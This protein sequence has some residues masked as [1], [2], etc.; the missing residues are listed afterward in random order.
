MFFSPLPTPS[1]WTMTPAD[2]ALP[3]ESGFRHAGRTLRAVT[4]APTSGESLRCP[5]ACGLKRHLADGRTLLELEP[6]LARQPTLS[7][8]LSVGAP[9]FYLAT[10]R[11]APASDDIWLDRFEPLSSG[12]T[13]FAI[14]FADGIAREPDQAAALL[15]PTID[16]ALGDDGWS[17]FAAALAAAFGSLLLLDEAGA[18]VPTALLTLTSASGE[19]RRLE[20]LPEH[21]G[22]LFLAGVASGDLPATLALAGAA[23]GQMQWVSAGDTVVAAPDSAALVPGLRAVMHADLH[24]WFAPQFPSGSGRPLPRYTRGNRVLPLVNGPAYFADLF[25]ELN[26]ISGAETPGFHLTGYRIDPTAV[27]IARADGTAASCLE[28]AERIAAAG[29]RSCFLPM[30]FMQLEPE[31]EDYALAITLFVILVHATGLV[32]DAHDSPDG[33]S[34]IND[35]G[36]VWATGLAAFAIVLLFLAA[37]ARGIELNADAVSLLNRPGSVSRLSAPPATFRD[38]PLAT[39]DDFPVSALVNLLHRYNVFHQKIALVRND[40][41]FVGYCGG[42]DLNPDRLDDERHLAAAPYHDVQA[43]VEGPALR[44]LA[45]TFEERWTRD[46]VGPPAFAAD[47]VPIVQFEAPGAAIVQV[48]RT[49]H[50][51]APDAPA[52][53]RLPFAPAGDRTLL[54]TTLQALSRA[55]EHVY[56]EDQYLT[57][58]P[59][60]ARALIRLVRER[61]IRSLVAV[62]PSTPD[63]LF[64]AGLRGEFVRA[65]R[66]AD[67]GAG[68]VQV[69]YARRSYQLAGTSTAAAK[70]RLILGNDV[71]ASTGS[72]VELRLGPASRLPPLPFWVCI[73]GELL[74]AVRQISA[75]EE[76]VTRPDESGTAGASVD[77]GVRNARIIAL[78]G[79]AT[80][81]LDARRGSTPRPHRTGAAATV[82]KL[83]GIYMHAKLML[84]DD[85]FAGI[86]SANVNRRGYFSD[87]ECNVFVVPEAL[88]FAA[89]NP[90]RR[91]RRTLWA[92]LLDLPIAFVPLLD[93]AIAASRLFRRSYLMGNR[94]APYEAIPAAPF[95]LS[96]GFTLR[97][98]VSGALRVGLEAVMATIATTAA[99]TQRGVFYTLSDP[100]SF[101][102]TDLG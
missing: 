28:A 60:Y 57:P 22:D 48:A 3:W 42:V 101:L 75:D 74:L 93:D 8:R 61:Q 100:S 86:G 72:E 26:A 7:A 80:N 68:I 49:Y 90:V 87:G 11:P 27:L 41:G 53:R 55:R 19:V 38:N 21:R 5:A 76:A 47:D 66:D 12:G 94:F 62:V 63:Q 45:V 20:L 44:D 71:E 24:R 13:T 56:I 34:L 15:L 79:E 92:E 2:L 51:A 37:D 39:P 65:L 95:D 96:A 82:L 67:G 9:T 35:G 1:S 43:R 91:L 73:D 59:E 30:E 84:I 36:V 6:L 18:P 69:G 81:L 88:R 83:D 85:V 4:L 89:D 14:A 98:D 32:V 40:A 70:G 77:V 46:G 31:V 99:A 97:P 58:P 10:D 29:G 33:G 23:A 17:A 52:E 102:Q 50:R 25:A 64:G 16:P 54:D 78:R